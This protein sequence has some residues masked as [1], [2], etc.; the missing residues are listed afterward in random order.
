MGIYKFLQIR[1]AIAGYTVRIGRHLW[2]GYM[3]SVPLL[4]GLP[5]KLYIAR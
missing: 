5:C 3:P 1:L 4:W 2:T